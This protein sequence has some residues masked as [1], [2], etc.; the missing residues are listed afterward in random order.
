MF[1]A[2]LYEILNSET[3]KDQIEYL[4]MLFF[5]PFFRSSHMIYG[6]T[7]PPNKT[8]FYHCW[9]PIFSCYADFF[10]TFLDRI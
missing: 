5:C 6:Y 3:I 2:K 10:P 9:E 4:G 1:V 7:Y 8:I